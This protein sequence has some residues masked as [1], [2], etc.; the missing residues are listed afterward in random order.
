LISILAVKNN[1]LDLNVQDYISI[2]ILFLSLILVY[3]LN[4]HKN[5][6]KHNPNSSFQ[7][8]ITA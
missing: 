3:A 6:T 5:K 8:L 7:Q 4:K 1:F 2:F